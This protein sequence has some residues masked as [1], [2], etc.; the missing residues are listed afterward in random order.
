MTQTNIGIQTDIQSNY[1]SET[2]E[3]ERLTI[4]QMPSKLNEQIIK[5]KIEVNFQ[6]DN[7]K[8]DSK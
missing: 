8:F 7:S 1:L 5:R 6:V 4:I 2:G 3:N